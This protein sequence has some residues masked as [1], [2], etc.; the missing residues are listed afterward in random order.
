MYGGVILPYSGPET[1]WLLPVHRPCPTQIGY[2]ALLFLPQPL[3]DKL[4]HAGS[5]RGT[6][7]MH[8][9]RLGISCFSQAQVSLFQHM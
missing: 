9:F 2:G 1:E 7:D 4:P 6:F 5:T 8:L 3:A